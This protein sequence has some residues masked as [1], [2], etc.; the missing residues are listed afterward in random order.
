MWGASSTQENHR[1]SVGHYRASRQTELMNRFPAHVVCDWLG[2]SQAIA[3]VHYL[4]TTPEHFAQAQGGDRVAQGVE[5]KVT[6]AVVP[7]GN[8]PQPLTTSETPE[9]MGDHVFAGA[10]DSV[11]APPAGIEPATPALGKPCSIP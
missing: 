2:N 7:D 8:E 10:C 5:T 6:E 3:A 9:N 4:T 1:K 11:E